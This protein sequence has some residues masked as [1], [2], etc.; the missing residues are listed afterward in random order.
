MFCSECGQKNIED[1]MF[2]QN[3][4]AALS[5]RH[6]GPIPRSMKK[7]VSILII[8]ILVG[9]AGIIYW[10]FSRS[11]LPSTD[12]IQRIVKEEIDKDSQGRIKLVSF[13]KTNAQKGELLGVKLYNFAYQI[14]IEFTE[15][16]KWVMGHGAMLGG[17]PQFKTSKPK[18]KDFW[19]EWTDNLNS[20][21]KLVKKG[22]KERLSGSI[23]FE[24][25]EK[26]WRIVKF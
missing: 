20:P 5:V 15:D 17:S 6:G 25:T 11:S 22:Q 16:C 2:C 7:L 19:E 26:G 3:C 14:E 4:G 21:G 18:S 24:K 8:F 13:Q 9:M 1:S 23:T 12:D 10:S